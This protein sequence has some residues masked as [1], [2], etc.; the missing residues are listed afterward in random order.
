MKRDR[1]IEKERER[2]RERDRERERER[3]GKGEGT[4]ERERERER[5]RETTSDQHP[6]RFAKRFA[7]ARAAVS[8]LV[9]QCLS[10]RFRKST[11]S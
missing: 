5:G 11:H 2:A 6:P 3:D 1:E 10:I 7:R 8:E 4:R 9:P